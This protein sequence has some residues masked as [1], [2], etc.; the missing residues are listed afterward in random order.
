MTDSKLGNF[1]EAR[2]EHVLRYLNVDHRYGESYLPRPFFV[3]FT[4]S[5]DSGIGAW[6]VRAT[7]SVSKLS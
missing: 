6:P 3:E 2:A 5:P 1:F 4:G 7:A